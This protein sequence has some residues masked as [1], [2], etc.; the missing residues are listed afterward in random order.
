[1]ALSVMLRAPQIVDV[2][3]VFSESTKLFTKKKRFYAKT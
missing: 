3:Q 1:M 2:E